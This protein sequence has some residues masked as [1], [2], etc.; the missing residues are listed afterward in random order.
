[1]IL[2][3][4]YGKWG[5]FLEF[6][7]FKFEGVNLSQICFSASSS[8][9]KSGISSSMIQEISNGICTFSPTSRRGKW[10]FLIQTICL[11]FSPIILLIVQNSFTFNDMMVWKNEI[12]LKDTLVTEARYLSN[13]I[14]NLQLERS[15]I[16]L[17]VFLDK[18]TGLQTDLTREFNATDNTL[19]ILKWRQFG[20][21]KIFQNKLR[22]QI[23]IDDFR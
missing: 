5:I 18:K 20:K 6:L 7:A 23:R 13:F 2:D 14:I 3:L 17:A 16:C 19:V 15:K 21:E 8:K 9:G 4:E 12:L 10:I 1:M 22:F 11:S